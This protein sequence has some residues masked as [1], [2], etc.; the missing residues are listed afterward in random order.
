MLATVI[1]PDPIE[2]VGTGRVAFAGGAEAVS[3]LLAVVSEDRVDFKSINRLRKP[4][5]DR[6]D[7][8]TKIST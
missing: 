4:L 6:A 7:L 5:A 8:S 3:K 2:G 1:G